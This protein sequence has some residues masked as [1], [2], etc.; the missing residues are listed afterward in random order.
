VGDR[1]LDSA[2][3]AYGRY[4][5][6]FRNEGKEVM[7]ARFRRAEL[8]EQQGRWEQARAEFRGLSTSSATDDLASSPWS[9]IV[10]H[11]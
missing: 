10:A 3:A 5:E 9:E 7:A 8:M 6:Y 4:I 1:R 11:H 2:V